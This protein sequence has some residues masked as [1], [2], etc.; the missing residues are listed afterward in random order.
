MNTEIFLSR[1]FSPEKIHSEIALKLGFPDY[2][3][4][5]SDALNDCLSEKDFCQADIYISNEDI[6]NKTI[7]DVIGVFKRVSEENK[8]ISFNI[9]NEEFLN[10]TDENGHITNQVK[11]RR[12]VHRDGN[13]HHTVH[14]WIIKRL[15]SSIYVLLQKRSKEK[16]FYPNCYDVSSAG[17]VSAGEETRYSAV[18]EIEEEL[19]IAADP[20]NLEYIGT[21]KT[22]K[23]CSTVDGD[24]TDREIATVYVY[25]KPV[26]IENLKLQKSEVS[27]VR[28][29]DIDECIA[30]INDNSFPNCLKFSEMMK[31]RKKIF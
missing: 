14:I 21:E 13:W 24:V 7:D 27:E 19:G 9:Y 5:N 20:R 8:R 10:V 6:A 17:H 31:L 1:R 11:P 23:S 26:E 30:R 15:D 12:L 2:Y 29:L 28:W 16:L 18:R 4:K 22:E 3:G 25:T